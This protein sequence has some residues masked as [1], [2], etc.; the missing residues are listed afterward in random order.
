MGYLVDVGYFDQ[1]LQVLAEDKPVIRAVWPAGPI[2]TPRSRRC[3][4]LLGRFGLIGDIVF[5]RVGVAV[6]RRAQD[7]RPWPGSFA[8]GVNMLVPTSRRI[9]SSVGVRAR[10]KKHCGS[11]RAPASWLSHDRFF[12][13]R[14]SI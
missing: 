2:P 7:G 11:S 14:L 13:T 9:T 5:Q 6:R 1:H 4:D 3:A 12:S 10:W 8:R